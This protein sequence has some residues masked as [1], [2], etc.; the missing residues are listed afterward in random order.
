MLRQRRRAVKLVRR[1][2]AL[3]GRCRQAI[4]R[5]SGKACVNGAFGPSQQ[6]FLTRITPGLVDRMECFL[7]QR[8]R[9]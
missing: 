5:T 2:Y 1:G 6:L 9:D 4:R 7:K 3:P 8:F